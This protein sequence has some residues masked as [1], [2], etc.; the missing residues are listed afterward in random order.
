MALRIDFEHKIRFNAEIQLEIYANAINVSQSRLRKLVEFM[1][2]ELPMNLL[3]ADQHDLLKKKT[4]PM[5][6]MSAE[7]ICQV[8]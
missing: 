1:F 4:R 5:R 6:N 3:I 2:I 8:I 7:I